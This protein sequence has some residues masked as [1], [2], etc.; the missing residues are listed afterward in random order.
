MDGLVGFALS[1]I[2]K[3]FP[4]VANDVKLQDWIKYG[5]PVLVVAAMVLILSWCCYC[6]CCQN[7]RKARKGPGRNQRRGRNVRYD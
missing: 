1:K 4:S 3:K 7:G 6:C 5:T 2:E